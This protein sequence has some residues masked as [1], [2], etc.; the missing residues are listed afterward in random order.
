MNEELL[1]AKKLASGDE[2]AWRR[3]LAEFRGPCYTLAKR[4][5]CHKHFEDFYSDLV[6]SLL[7]KDLK[8]YRGE[9][10]LGELV[11]RRFSNIVSTYMH[12][13]KRRNTMLL[14]DEHILAP[15][16]SHLAEEEETY[17]LLGKARAELK[18]D[19][20]KLLEDYYFKALEVPENIWLYAG[21]PHNI[22]PDGSWNAVTA[23]DG[24]FL[25]RRDN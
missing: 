15:S 9:R 11:M 22:N 10:P 25:Y 12:K 19:E 18:G 21:I 7:K 3:F 14:Y 24:T 13:A 16:A 23:D 5:R 20:K 8:R 4:Y 1:T 2:T 6:F 17:E